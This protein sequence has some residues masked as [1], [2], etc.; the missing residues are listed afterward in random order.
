MDAPNKE[1]VSKMVAEVIDDMFEGFQLIDREWRYVYVNETVARQGKK[2]AGELIGKTM[3]ECY[4]GIE[5]TRMFSE[6][7]S[8]QERGVNIRMENEFEYPDGSKGWFQL[9]MHSVPVGVMILSID[10]T[11]RKEAELALKEKVRELQRL[12][13]IAVDRESKMAELKEKI[14]RLLPLLPEG[15]DVPQEL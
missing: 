4:P 2:S 14:D 5:E 11:E 1:D 12:T 9:Y 8:C 10:I 13:E 3:M 15:T 7:K 6:L